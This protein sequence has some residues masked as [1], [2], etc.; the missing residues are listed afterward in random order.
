MRSRGL[1]QLVDDKSVV[2]CHDQQTDC[3][4]LLS[5]DL[6]EIASTRGNKSAT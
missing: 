3:Q 5:T 4:N 2:I 6:L 1:R